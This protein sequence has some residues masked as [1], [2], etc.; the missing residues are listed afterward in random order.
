MNYL[1]KFLFCAGGMTT[2]A[3]VRSVFR[4]GVLNNSTIFLAGITIAIFVYA[5][6]FHKLIKMKWL[7]VSIFTGVVVVLAFA[8]ALG[9]YGRR[10]TVDFAEGA[11][12]VLG[13]GTRDGV[14]RSPLARRL[15]MAAE[16]HR[17]NPDAIIVVSGGVGHSETRSEAAIMADFLVNLGVPRDIIF[18]EE[19]AYSTYSN[20]RYSLVIIEEVFG[21]SPPVA[22][23]TNDFHMYRSIRFARQVGFEAAAWPSATP[24]YTLPF[25]YAREVA[26]VV[27]LWVLGT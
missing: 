18:L 27:K 16:Y 23:V 10:A 8:L 12:I 3:M 17:Y 26:A 22:V 19:R 21:Y 15:E 24:W 9:I 6:Y 25:N 13:A 1:Q 14:P 20:M 5:Y 2:I 7:T 4:S 11:V